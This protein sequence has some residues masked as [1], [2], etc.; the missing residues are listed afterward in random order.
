MPEFHEVIHTRGQQTI[1]V[2]GTF[3]SGLTVGALTL[4]QHT[5]DVAAIFTIAGE[6]DTA[7][8]DLDDAR[9]AVKNNFEQLA[10]V[11]IRFSRA[12]EG[13]IE[14]TSDL[15]GELADCRAIEPNAPEN[16]VARGRRVIK[17]VAR[18]NAERAAATP[19]LL[20]L[21]IKHAVAG[22][23][24]ITLAQL[25]TLVTNMPGLEQGPHWR[26]TL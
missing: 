20:A 11:V 8:D 19:P 21:T 2:W 24:D 17:V 22:Q 14:P 7:Q 5:M 16:A 23:P 13:Q 26:S 12:V 9:T 10:D 6:R 4:A 15:H 3:A 25:Q 18:V 1:G